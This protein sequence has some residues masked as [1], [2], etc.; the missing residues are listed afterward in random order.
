MA[1]AQ[2]QKVQQILTDEANKFATRQNLANNAPATVA[3]IRSAPAPV[4]N[5]VVSPSQPT[6]P[7][8]VR[9]TPMP[10]QQTGLLGTASSPTKSVGSNNT[11]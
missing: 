3:P 9:S 7:P 2:A 10:Q 6:T 4:Y 1:L 8:P 5:P 11:N